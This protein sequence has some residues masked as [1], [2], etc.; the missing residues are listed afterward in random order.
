M[1][2]TRANGPFTVEWRLYW[3]KEEVLDDKWTLPKLERVHRANTFQSWPKEV[4][5]SHALRVVPAKS[6]FDQVHA[7]GGP[8]IEVGENTVLRE[9]V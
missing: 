5:I 4:L 8:C 1:S 2:A 7:P 9:R 6:G 3:P